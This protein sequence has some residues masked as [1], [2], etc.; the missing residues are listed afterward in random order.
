MMRRLIGDLWNVCWRE[1]L[2][3][4]RQRTRILMSIV[5]PVIWLVLLGNMMSGI[6]KFPG[7]SQV[8]GSQ[9][10]V[11]FMTPGIMVMTTLFGGIFTGGLSVVWDRRFGYLYRLLTS[12]ISRS[13]I[14]LGKMVASSL[15][16]GFQVVLII[17][18]ALIFG[19][20]FSTG[21]AGVVVMIL[22]VM[23]F[24]FG[25]AGISVGL[26]A[27]IKRMETMMAVVN[28]FTMPLMFTSNALFPTQLMPKWLATIAK[29]N[30]VSYVVAPLRELTLGGWAWATILPDLGILIIFGV[31]VATAASFLFRRKFI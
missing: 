26:G 15:Q 21:L 1:L 16:I 9:N 30:P 24:G 29:F 14:P 10:Y 6:V 5:Q 12:P 2:H 22:I 11:T 8:F 25:I 18:I 13:S 20:R 4:I 19:V 27:V 3:F 23:L 31:V 7:A 17:L 28:F